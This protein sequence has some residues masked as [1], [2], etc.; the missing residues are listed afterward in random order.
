MKFLDDQ[1]V[2]A[3]VARYDGRPIA[4]EAFAAFSLNTTAVSGTAVTFAQDTA[5]AASEGT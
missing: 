5:N 3:G 1:T 2:F 4:G